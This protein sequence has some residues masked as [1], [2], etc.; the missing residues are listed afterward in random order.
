VTD[1]EQILD[2]VRR[3][4][5]TIPVLA[6]KRLGVHRQVAARLLDALVAERALARYPYGRSAYCTVSRQP[7]SPRVLRERFA[8]AWFCEMA[9][10]PRRLLAAE[11]LLPLVRD[12]LSPL[13]LDVLP[14]VPSYYDTNSRG[15]YAVHV[16][17][18]LRTGRTSHLDA[19]LR[20]L[21]RLVVA[22]A[23]RPW[24][25]LCA[26]GRGGLAYLHPESRQVDEL[27][28][29][30]TRHPLYGRFEPSI[31]VARQLPHEAIH[32]P[33]QLDALRVLRPEP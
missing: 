3:T 24:L 10:Q 14:R 19:T 31:P 26:K 30:L 33:V 1:R 27:R 4:G 15:I 6:A 2:Q 20:A 17:T 13:G 21:Q 28:R 11:E 5:I 18:E 29:W 25:Y 9:G 7:L 22:P 23:F 16:P 8:V 12:V 32:V